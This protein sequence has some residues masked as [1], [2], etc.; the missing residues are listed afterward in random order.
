MGDLWAGSWDTNVEIIFNWREGGREFWK[1]ELPTFA[2]ENECDPGLP[3][4]RL[5]V[6]E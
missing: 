4:A 1:A 2:L 3:A 5:Q 6:W